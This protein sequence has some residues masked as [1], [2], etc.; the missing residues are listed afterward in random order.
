MAPAEGRNVC[1]TWGWG[2]GQGRV[3]GAYGAR[4]FSMGLTGGDRGSGQRSARA[5]LGLQRPFW[6]YAE[7]RQLAGTPAMRLLLGQAER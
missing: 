2:G 4:P 3:D 7:N 5:G 1:G 6:L